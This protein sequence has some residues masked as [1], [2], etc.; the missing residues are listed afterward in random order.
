MR[1]SISHREFT[2]N[3]SRLSITQYDH[4]KATLEKN[5]ETELAPASPYGRSM[6]INL[7]ILFGLG[8]LVWGTNEINNNIAR[9]GTLWDISNWVQGISFLVG[10]YRALQ[11]I[12]EIGSYVQFADEKNKYYSYLKDC[13]LNSSNYSEFKHSF[14]LKY[15]LNFNEAYE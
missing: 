1:I 6:L 11:Y 5:R 9:S 4:L 2:F 13:L 15:P 10:L 12:F 7:L 3:P 14:R 8:F